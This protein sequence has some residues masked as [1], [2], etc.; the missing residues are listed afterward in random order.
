[1]RDKHSHIVITKVG[2]ADDVC[3]R[4]IWCR[5][6]HTVDFISLSKFKHTL[7]YCLILLIDIFICL[8][9]TAVCLFFINVLLLP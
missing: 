4:L 5:L 2:T 3:F 7:F 6:P 1:M 9:L 8:V